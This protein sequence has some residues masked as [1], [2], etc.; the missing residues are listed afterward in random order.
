[1]IKIIKFS[2]SWCGPCRTLAP[3]MNEVKQEHSDILF[4]DVD[5]DEQP[6]LA[7]NHGINSVPT[8][9]IMKNN[10]EVCRF[11]GVKSKSQINNIINQYK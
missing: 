1:M 7:T 3:I 8:I 10:D 9:I 4:V 6:T 2:A 11:T 5:V